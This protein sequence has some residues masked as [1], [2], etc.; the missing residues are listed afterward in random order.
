[1]E[2]QNE[3]D[4]IKSDDYYPEC[5]FT[6]D[7]IS[8]NQLIEI[9]NN[10]KGCIFRIG[11]GKKF[12]TGFLCK[13]PFSYYERLP[14]L[15]TCN[16]VLDEESLLERDSIY[17]TNEYNEKYIIKKDEKR[18]YYSNKN[19]LDAT[20]IEI[21]EQ[22]IICK[23][24]YLDVDN[25]NYSI[26][27]LSKYNAYLFHYQNDY[28]DLLISF[29]TF[30]CMEGYKFYHYCNSKPGSS[31]GPIFN[32][33]NNKVYGIHLGSHKKYD[34]KVGTNLKG[35]IMEFIKK[36]TKTKEEKKNE[37]KSKNENENYEEQISKEKKS[38]EHEY[39][40]ENKRKINNENY[41]KIEGRL[42]ERKTDSYEKYNEE[43]Y[44]ERKIL[45][46]KG[47]DLFEDKNEEA[48]CSCC[49]SIL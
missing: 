15:I 11:N 46:E 19:E 48:I 2:D 34:M 29:A 17:L 10:I 18:K 1:M 14:V 12:G 27:S 49:S 8:V 28:P 44:N 3:K 35:P 26:E 21:I 31:G 47:S 24:K 5:G 32:S 38:D 37:I 25:D 16:H 9:M 4:I 7:A 43:I 33:Y 30:K 42:K 40:N 6:H 22:D 41:E 45:E 23:A 20:I 36:Y 39:K 13:I